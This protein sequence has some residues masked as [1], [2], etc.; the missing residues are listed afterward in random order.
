MERLCLAAKFLYNED[1]IKKHKRIL[2][3]EKEQRKRNNQYLILKLNY[4]SSLCIIEAESEKE[5]H[6]KIT[7]MNEDWIKDWMIDFN[8][9]LVGDGL[10]P[11]KTTLDFTKRL[12]ED[13]EFKIIK[14]NRL[15]KEK[16]FLDSSIGATFEEM[17]I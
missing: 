13:G 17:N 4:A 8:R 6:E 12:I 5:L 14:L 15:V 7:L 10:E 11:L 16:I 2:E 1:I 3:L 9:D